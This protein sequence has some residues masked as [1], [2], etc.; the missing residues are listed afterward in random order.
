MM[1]RKAHAAPMNL[2]L[3]QSGEFTE[4]M[5]EEIG[6]AAYGEPF[7]EPLPCSAAPLAPR[8]LARVA[9]ITSRRCH[10]GFSWHNA[11][12]PL[13]PANWKKVLE[14]ASPDYI[15]IESCIHDSTRLWPQLAHGMAEHGPIIR[16]II[17]FGSR[18]GIP[19]IF[20]HTLGAAFLPYFDSIL[21]ECAIVAC[22]DEV[23]CE[24]LGRKGIQPCFLPHAFSP[25]QFNPLSGPR[26]AR[27]DSRLVFDGIG[28]LMRSE[29]VRKAVSA[30]G[31]ADLAI[32][33]SGFFAPPY[34]LARSAAAP[35][36][37]KILGSISQTLIQEL[38]KSSGGYLSLGTKNEGFAPV[39]EQRALEAA[40]CRVPVL[41]VG[42]EGGI[43]GTFARSFD[44]AAEASLYWDELLAKPVCRE[45]EA[46]LAWRNAHQRHTFA[47]RMAEIHGWLGLGG[48][49][50]PLPLASVVAPSSRA[51][52]FPDVLR[53]YEAQTWPNRELVF[54]FNGPAIAMPKAPKGRPDVRVI[55]VPPEYAVGSVMNA[56]LLES[57]GKYF[58]RMDD[59]DWYGPNYLS[60]RMIYF[61]EFDIDSMSSSR[62]WMNFSDAPTARL[63]NIDSIPQDNT[64][65]ALGDATY[66]LL[67]FTGGSFAAKVEFARSLGF[68]EAA[69][70][71]ADVAF[72]Y[73]GMFFA[74]SSAHLKTDPFNFCVRRGNP[75]GHT[76]G[77]SQTE[78]DCFMESREA[79]L[80]DVFV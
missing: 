10:E 74:P 12:I 24:M 64:V 44:S 40:A 6:V 77:A 51:E 50:V 39:W 2:R 35:F 22:A 73:K 34:N 80:E 8:K 61:N 63:T 36:R 66:R 29:E 5:P 59:D 55:H 48:D 70:S 18:L 19:A 47:H 37:E 60:D 26:L 28:R 27:P 31:E 42:K 65:F 62:A 52:N 54:V 57:R 1:V 9:T 21:H 20:W 58:F 16:E 75:A 72:L 68:V 41:H 76:W 15:L 71:H 38:Y 49:P 53:R 56:G 23:S 4:F 17:A 69:H 78:L 13:S 79:P 33:D 45:K 25:E 14:T 3:G 32:V 11:C 67:G 30:F 46:H 7:P 43:T